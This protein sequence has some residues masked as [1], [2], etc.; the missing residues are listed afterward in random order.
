MDTPVLTND[1]RIYKNFGL[2]G[3][4]AVGFSILA[5]GAVGLYMSDR[6]EEQYGFVP[7]KEEKEKVD[8]LFPTVTVVDRPPGK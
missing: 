3:R 1:A 4:L 2:K 5:W 7:S 8:R 6:A